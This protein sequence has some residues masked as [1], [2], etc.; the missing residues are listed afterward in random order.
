M[1]EMIKRGI[2]CKL[3]VVNEIL[4]C[5]VLLYEVIERM[6]DWRGKKQESSSTKTEAKAAPNDDEQ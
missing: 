4:L 1:N 5:V 6:K 3:P 2:L